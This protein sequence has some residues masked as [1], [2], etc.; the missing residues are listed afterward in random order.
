MIEFWIG[1][2]LYIRILYD[3]DLFICLFVVY[4]VRVW[5]FFGKCSVRDDLL[6]FVI[7]G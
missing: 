3:I 5:G 1:F 4:S 7:V 2:I 6:I